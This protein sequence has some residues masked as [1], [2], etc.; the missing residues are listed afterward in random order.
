MWF[1]R[2]LPYIKDRTIPWHSISCNKLERERECHPASCLSSR[3]EPC[4]CSESVLSYHQRPGRAFSLAMKPAAS[5][6]RPRGPRESWRGER[7]SHSPRA[8]LCRE[9]D[10]LWRKY[11]TRL[12]NPTLRKCKRRQFIQIM[13][14]VP[15][16]SPSQCRL[17]YTM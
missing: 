3:R 8:T 16:P 14:G 13:H 10:R 12:F 15:R 1:W 4:Q 7:R 6:S 17:Y 11:A 9:R 2:P 5:R